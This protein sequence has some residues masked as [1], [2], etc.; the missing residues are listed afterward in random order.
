MKKNIT[1]VTLLALLLGLSAVPVW[2]Q[3]TG[4]LKGVAKDEAGKPIA[5]ATVEF[6]NTETGRKVTLKTDKKGEYFSV[7]VP[8]GT[9]NA[10]LSANGKVIDQVSRIPVS[11]N[12][13][14]IVNFDL[15]KD[16]APGMTEEQ[17][18]KIEEAQKQNDKIKNLNA[19]LQEA[20]T[21]EQAN[22]WD[23]AVALLQP[24]AEANPDKDLLWAYLGDAYRGDK[25]YPESA[26]AYQKAIA[27]KPTSGAYHNGLAE[28]YAKSGQTDKA[29]AEYNTA[30]QVEP[31]NA[32][33]YYFNEGA[34]L[35]NQGKLDE[36]IAAFDKT[37]AADPTRADAY[38]W[39]GVNLLGKATTKGDKMV[40]PP[41]T[42][43]AFNKYL[44]LAPDGKYAQPT[45][46]MLASMGATVQTTY[47]KGKTAKS[48]TPPK[49]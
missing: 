2:A 25:K 49:K 27:L 43:E 22:N 13:E 45:K 42:E 39:K 28:A 9:Y 37:I 12:E 47:G 29:I 21:L 20:K 41:G 38:Y 19:T 40:A 5:D 11:V 14:R 24:A 15:A 8:Q 26:D 16:K 36:A 34:V 18:K 46:D 4:T 30:A 44:E 7:G 32:A 35:T 6:T 23:Q 1:L 17:K 48:T 31:A 10:A 33:M 3:S